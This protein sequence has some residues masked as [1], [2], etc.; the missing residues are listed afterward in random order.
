MVLSIRALSVA[1]VSFLMGAEPYIEWDRQDTFFGGRHQWQ[2]R[3][4]I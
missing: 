2:D 3:Q 1:A 4:Y